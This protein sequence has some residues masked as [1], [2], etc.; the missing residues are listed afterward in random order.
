MFPK[1]NC[2]FVF[3]LAVSISDPWNVMDRLSILMS[4][5]IGWMP[6]TPVQARESAAMTASSSRRRQS[7]SEKE[8]EKCHLDII[9]VIPGLRGLWGTPK[10]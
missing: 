2:L 8:E 1:I 9:E 5:D 4:L 3:F 6:R 7:S 10:F